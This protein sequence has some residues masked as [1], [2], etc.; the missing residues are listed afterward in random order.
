MMPARVIHTTQTSVTLTRLELLLLATAVLAWV[1]SLRSPRGHERQKIRH[2]G[3]VLP[4]AAAGDSAVG[5][6]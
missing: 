1:R 5:V 6:P 4:L 3:P 2:I